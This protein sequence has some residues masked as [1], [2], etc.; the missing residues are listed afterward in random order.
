VKLQSIRAT[1]EKTTATPMLIVTTLD[2]GSTYARAMLDGKGLALALA[3]A[4][5]STNASATR[6]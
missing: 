2:M 4:Q 6:A 3:A 1:D 5:T